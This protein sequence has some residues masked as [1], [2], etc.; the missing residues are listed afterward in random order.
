MALG[1]TRIEVP[2]RISISPCPSVK[3]LEPIWRDLEG[4]AEGS[5]CLS[6]AW[7][8]ALIETFQTTAWIATV[9]RGDETIGLALLG[10][11]Q[12]RF[13]FLH[14][15][16]FVHLNETGDAGADSIMIEYNGLL[17]ESGQEETVA[18]SLINIL[19]DNENPR[20]SELVLS[21]VSLPPWETACKNNG[22]SARLLRHHQVAPYADL[23]QMNLDDPMRS[24]SRNNR[25]K[26]KQSIRYFE[27]QGPLTLQRAADLQQALQWFEEMERLH[28]ASWVNR[29]KS[30]AFANV[31]FSEFHRNL[32]ANSFERGI[33][34][35]LRLTAGD[36]I[37][38][39]LYNLRWR[40]I[41]YSYQSGFLYGTESRWRP[42]LV[43]HV[44]AI[45][46][47]SLEGLELYRFLAGDARYK[48][49]L[50]NGHDELFWMTVYRPSLFRSI[51]NR[52][53]QLRQS[54]R[55]GTHS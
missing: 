9:W 38:G 29:G 50:S 37:L 17:A 19:F 26:I 30:G 41:A 6:W 14:A 32:I 12:S 55:L 21:G 48:K 4:R 36:T 44:L 39:Y 20:C 24:L 53:R 8:G 1:S 52:A 2:I 46:R 7:I 54:I 23:R 47:Y 42:G 13:P 15:T 5:V 40:N 28:T 18:Q 35:L 49:S 27:E 22:L 10:V 11:R 45:R 51:E 25:E 3:Q 34:D 33:P 43:A 16:P 31:R